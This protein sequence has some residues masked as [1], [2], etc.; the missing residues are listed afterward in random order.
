MNRLKTRP[1]G[2]Y[3][4]V[5]AITPTPLE[6]VKHDLPPVWWKVWV[7]VAKCGWLVCVNLRR[8]YYE[9]QRF[10]SRWR[11]RSTDPMTNSLWGSPETS[12]IL[13]MPITYM[14]ALTSRMQHERNILMSIGKV[15]NMRRLEHWSKPH[16]NAMDMDFCAQVLRNIVIGLAGMDGYLMQS[17]LL[18]AVSSS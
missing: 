16:R 4:E 5:T 1:D 15:S 8:S 13:W 12:M 2:K 9:Y 11:K 14:V 3:I 7:N 6:K 10:G 18:F 17:G